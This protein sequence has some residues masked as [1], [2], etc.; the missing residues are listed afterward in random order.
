MQYSS[1]QFLAQVL[2]DQLAGIG[3][4]CWI[5]GMERAASMGVRA[6]RLQ[7]A[8]PSLSGQSS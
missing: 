5:G 7:V 2:L 8:L 4:L 3:G 6:V 1:V